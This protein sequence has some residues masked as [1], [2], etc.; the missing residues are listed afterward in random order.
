MYATVRTILALC[1]DEVDDEYGRFLVCVMDDDKLLCRVLSAEMAPLVTS[2][3]A[4]A[5]LD[6]CC[7]RRERDL[8]G[9]GTSTI[10]KGNSPTPG[11]AGTYLPAP[12][13]PFFLRSPP[14]AGFFLVGRSLA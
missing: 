10:G 9:L 3:T 12:G 2:A 11:A 13:G 1:C 6:R 5:R 7:T 8:D 14:G 4:T